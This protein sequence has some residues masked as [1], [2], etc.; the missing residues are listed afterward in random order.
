MRVRPCDLLKG[1]SENAQ[2]LLPTMSLR[3]I[4]ALLATPF[5]ESDDVLNQTLDLKLNKSTH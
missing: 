4:L 2:C 3:G 1:T 5:P